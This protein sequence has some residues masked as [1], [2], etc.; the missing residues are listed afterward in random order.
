[1]VG[2]GRG[3]GIEG[4]QCSYVPRNTKQITKL[5]GYLFSESP[6]EKLNTK[7]LLVVL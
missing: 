4:M 3:G 7:M 5:V 2:G 1:M 6:K